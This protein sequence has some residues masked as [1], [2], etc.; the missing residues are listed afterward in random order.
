MSRKLI[1]NKYTFVLSGYGSV[2]AKQ[3]TCLGF[4]GRGWIYY[5]VLNTFDSH[6]ALYQQTVSLKVDYK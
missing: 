6:V 4:H 3:R 5:R 1:T 2:I